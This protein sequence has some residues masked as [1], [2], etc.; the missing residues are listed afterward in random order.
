MRVDF[1]TTFGI[2]AGFPSFPEAVLARAL[3]ADGHT[4]RA[5]T[6]YAKS[7]PMI[8]THHEVIDGTQVHRIRRKGMITPG[9]LGWIARQTPDVAHIHHH[10]N[11]LSVL[12]LPA[13]HARRVPVIFS[14]YG[15]LHDPELVVDTDRPLDA[16]LRAERIT[17][18]LPASARTL[19]LRHGS[20]VWALHRPL[21]VADAIHAMSAHEAKILA[22]IGVPPERIHFIPVGIDP[23]LLAA[24][25]PIARTAHPTVLFLGQTKYRKGWDVLMRAI[26]DVVRACPE[27]RFVFVGH[28]GRDRADFDA[29]VRELGVAAVIDAPG[30]VDEAEKV[31]LLHSSWVLTLPA[32]YEGFGIPLVEAMMVRTPVVTTDVAACNEIVQNEIT[33]LTV[34]PDDPASLAAALIRLLGDRTLRDRLGAAGKAAAFQ[35]YDAGVVARQFETLYARV[36]QGRR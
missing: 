17:P 31:R 36:R 18:S 24:P 16:P 10:S 11:R 9:T 13:Y 15:V 19:G 14:P 34:P 20:F 12:A 4:V 22:Q 30:R 3:T 29:L 1:V 26:P 25:A 5:L 32:R 7:S 21:F 27:A 23:T 8:D 35:R 6:Y 28:T 2:I 33:G